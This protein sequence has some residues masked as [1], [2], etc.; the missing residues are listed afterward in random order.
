MRKFMALA[1]LVFLTCLSGGSY[2][3]EESKESAVKVT[4]K[5]VEVDSNFDGKVDRTEIYD[6]QGQI[7][8][9]EIDSDANG[10]I[11]EWIIYE[12][13]KP[14]QNQRDSNKDGKVDVWIEY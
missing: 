9:V 8:R 6:A 1:V 7:L 4:P 10:K 2:A 5:K 12:K 3:A 14:V 11:D 13:G